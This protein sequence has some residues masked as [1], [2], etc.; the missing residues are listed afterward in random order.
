[1]TLGACLHFT[2][3]ST[4]KEAE[5]KICAAPIESRNW[6]GANFELRPIDKKR[7]SQQEA[8]VQLRP[9]DE[10]VFRQP[11]ASW[12][13]K[14]E[15]R[16]PLTRRGPLSKKPRFNSAHLTDGSSANRLPPGA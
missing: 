15:M 5:Y 11:F 12:R 2:F 16:R 3:F 10:R 14:I 9:S 7:A 1:M 4:K 13:L 6:G 8:P